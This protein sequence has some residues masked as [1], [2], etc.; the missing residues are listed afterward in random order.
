MSTPDAPEFATALLAWFDAHQRILPW[1]DNRD[2][3]RIWVSEVMLQQTQVK[4]VIPHFE[5]FLRRFPTIH[6]LS[7]ADEQTVLREWEG[8]GY[9][10]RAKH[11]HQAAKQLAPLSTNGLP[12][13]PKT[14]EEL[15]GV[16]RY[17]L[18]AVLSQAFDLRLP[19][20]EA[21]TIRVLS[22]LFAYRD[23]PRDTTGKKWLWQTAERIL[24]TARIGD[25]NQALMEL[26]AL[27]CTPD[28]PACSKCPVASFCAANHL[29]EQASIP[30]APTATVIESVRE[31]AVILRRAGR[32]LLVQRPKTG[33]WADMWEFPRTVL[34]TDESNDQAAG[35]LLTEQGIT[36]K[37]D[38]QFHELRHGVTR[39]RIQL[40]AWLADHEAGEFAAIGYQNQVW[41]SL[42]ELANYP[43]SVP[44]RQLIQRLRSDGRSVSLF[45]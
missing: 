27:V 19:I 38:C 42:E 7:A 22:R 40:A 20:V 14:W 17:I 6:D 25:F 18:G 31:V 36:A 9:Y 21:N 35:R 41:T 44:Q 26:G 12:S 11:L 10:R 15:P 5:R 8:L 45:D 4:T 43:V 2:A 33:R 1:R 16:G 30:M 32:M 37:L 3:Y 28:A 29:G 34:T 23:D 13:D 39:Y 24:P